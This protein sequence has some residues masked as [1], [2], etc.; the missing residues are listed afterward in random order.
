MEHYG[1]WKPAIVAA[2]ACLYS[3]LHLCESPKNQP[4]YLKQSLILGPDVEARTRL[5][6]A[7]VL[8]EW[9]EDSEGGEEEEHH[10]KRALMILPTTDH[11]LDLR[12][13]IVAAQCRLFLRRGE[14]KW[15]EQKMKSA[16]SD[17]QQRAQGHWVH[18]FMLKLSKLYFANN[19][20]R[21]SINTLQFSIRWARQHDDIVSEAVSSVQQLGILVYSRS[22]STAAS[23]ITSLAELINDKKL[24]CL[25]QIRTRFWVLKASALAMSGKAVEAQEACSSARQALKEWQAILAKGLANKN[26]TDGGASFTVPGTRAAGDGFK[27]RGWSYYEA[28]AWVMLVSALCVRGENV[29][30]ESSGYLRLAQEGI[31]K[32][33]LDGAGQML[34]PI[35][36]Q[37]LLHKIDICLATLQMEQ[38]QKVLD[39]VMGIVAEA[40]NQ[41]RLQGSNSSSEFWRSNRDAIAL[42]WAMFKHRTGR[43]D[44]AIDAYQC[45]ASNGPADIQYAARVNLVMLYLSAGGDD[46]GAD[47]QQL[48]GSMQDEISTAPN[49]SHELVRQALLDFLQGVESKE[50]VKAKTHLLACLRA[51]SQI[52]ETVLQGWTLCMLGTLVLPTGQYDQAMKMCAAGQAI[53]QKAQDP[54]QN[55]AAISILADIEKAVGDQ[56]RCEKLLQVSRRCLEQ[57]DAKTRGFS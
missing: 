33:E 12:Y 57:F 37:V 23:L 2:L 56:E 13:S 7:Q 25:P 45:V 51:C 4:R 30:E 31:V 53:A 20:V 21:S 16:F 9:C 52:A 41:R 40:E 47:V 38:A 18:Y 49:G 43:F 3:I 28:H 19:D 44:E 15:A 46:R 11:Y 34:L 6:V 27:I 54:L 5:R 17:A 50:P 26:I 22:W 32:G 48:L 35:R 29:R 10:L 39:Q 55:A 14:Q 1:D 42:R 8:S 24:S 36:L